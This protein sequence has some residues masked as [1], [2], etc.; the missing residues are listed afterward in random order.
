MQIIKYWPL[1]TH[2]T[3]TINGPCIIIKGIEDNEQIKYNAINKIISLNN[4]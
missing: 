4:T 2:H 1:H 3:E